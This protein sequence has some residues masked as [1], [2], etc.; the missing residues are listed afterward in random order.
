VYRTRYLAF[1]NALATVTGDRE[2]ARDAVQEAFSQALAQR[3][4]L[5]NDEAL[6][7]WIW[8]IAL[9]AALRIRARNDNVELADALDPRL[10]EPVLDAELV[11]AVR[12]LPPQRR[13]IFFLRYFADLSY[14]RIGEICDVSDGTVAASLSEARAQLR[15]E[16]DR[17]EPS[18]EHSRRIEGARHG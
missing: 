16:L 15:R 8:K 7:A 6:E 18:E 5:R 14:S 17:H 3:R 2:S 10:P 4:K 1:R 9:R 13:L 11:A 12:K